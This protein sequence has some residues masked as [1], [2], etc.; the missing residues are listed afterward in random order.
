MKAFERINEIIMTLSKERV[1]LTH[2]P[3]LRELEGLV[4]KVEQCLGLNIHA[5]AEAEANARALKM[6]ADRLR[7]ELAEAKAENTS[8]NWGLKSYLE[9]EGENERLKHENAA[10]RKGTH[11]PPMKPDYRKAANDL[12]H[13][14]NLLLKVM[15]DEPVKMSSLRAAIE[16]AKQAQKLLK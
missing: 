15:D 9:L 2:A 11:V 4:S 3:E 8:K 10:L 12:S 7:S 5:L 14:F 16:N 6:E 1:G 13:A